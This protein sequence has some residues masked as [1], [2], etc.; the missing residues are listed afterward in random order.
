MPQ[1]DK[2]DEEEGE[3]DDEDNDG[4]DDDIRCHCKFDRPLS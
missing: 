4:N 3:D 2:K 1:G